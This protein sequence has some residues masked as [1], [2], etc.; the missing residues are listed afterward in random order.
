MKNIRTKK[1]READ[2][3][4]ETGIEKETERKPDRQKK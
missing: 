2:R 1:E 3:E 4:N